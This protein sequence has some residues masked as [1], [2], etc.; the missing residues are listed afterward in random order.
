MSGGRTLELSREQI[1]A[2]GAG[3]RPSTS[4]STGPDSLRHA[5]WAG[6]QDSVP[7]SALHSLHARVEGFAPTPWMTRRWCR[8]GDRATPSTSCPRRPRAIHARSDAREGP[9]P[10]SAEDYAVRA[11]AHLGGRKLR[12]G[13]VA[14]ALGLGNANAIRYATLTGTI[15]IRWAGARQPTIWT[16]PRPAQTAADQVGLAR[17]T[18]TS[19]AQPRSRLSCAGAGWRVRRRWPRSTRWAT[20]ADGPDA[21]GRRLP[22]P[23]MRRPFARRHCRPMSPGCCPAVTRTTS[24]WGADREFLVPDAATARRLWTSRVWPGALLLGGEIVGTW[25]RSKAE[26]AVAP[27]RTL[28]AGTRSR[29]GR[30]GEPAPPR[31]RASRRALGPGTDHP[32]SMTQKRLPLGIGQDHEVGIRRHPFPLHAAGSQPDQAFDLGRLVIGV[33]VQVDLGRYLDALHRSRDT[34]G[35][36]PSGGRSSENPDH[37]DRVARSGAP[38]TRSRPCDPGRRPG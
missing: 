4:G 15:L 34:F 6:L 17:A 13:D 28:S 2:L 14:D 18:C 21:T 27:W 19:S 33:E 10:G 7:R 23:R 36:L 29:R 35:P 38:A 3:S 24:L 16:V 22:W 9:A 5:A 26:V 8:S 30:S 1:L 11:H 20:P 37:C 32:L 31:C 25:R 12:M